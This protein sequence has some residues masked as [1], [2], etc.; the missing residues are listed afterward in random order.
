MRVHKMHNWKSDDWIT[1]M[2]T[3]LVGIWIDIIQI[4]HL[5]F[6]NFLDATWW[7]TVF[8]NALDLFWKMIITGACGVTGVLGKKWMEE[9]YPR[10]KT[11]ISK[12]FKLKTKK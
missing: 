6:I 8:S 5:G 1:A 3:G 10:F 4:P 12:Y 7:H 2:L 11:W 9:N